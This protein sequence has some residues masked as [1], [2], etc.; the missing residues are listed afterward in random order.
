LYETI[1]YNIKDDILSAAGSPGKGE[2]REG[3][4]QAPAATSTPLSPPNSNLRYTS[5]QCCRSRMFI[6]EI[7]YFSIP[8]FSP[9]FFLPGSRIRIKEFKYSK[10]SEMSSGLFI[11]D[12]DPYFLSI[13][14]PGAKKAP[15]PGSRIRIRN[16]ASILVTFS[17]PSALMHGCV[18]LKTRGF[19]NTEKIL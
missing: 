15:D 4:Q 6:P 5:I 8:D 19:P 7:G 12:P 10:P 17:R 14:D 1:Q 9:N 13:P 11:S 18:A 16:T 2:K 3:Q